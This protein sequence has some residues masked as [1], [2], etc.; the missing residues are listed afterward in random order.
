MCKII[1][2]FSS[3]RNK[4][5]LVSIEDYLR[6]LKIH[7]TKE[8]AMYEAEVLGKLR[9]YVN[10]PKVVQ[11]YSNKLYL[12]YINGK[13]AIEYFLECSINK[14]PSL[15][16]SMISFCKAY[17]DL[18]CDY[19]LSDTN[20][21]N[22]ILV[23]KEDSIDLFGIDFEEKKEGALINS[24]ANLCAFAFLYDVCL[25]KKIG[26][27]NTILEEISHL[28][29]TQN[30]LDEEVLK[31]LHWLINRRKLE[32]KANEVLDGIKQNCSEQGMV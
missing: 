20:F 21:R 22:F 5:F 25:E 2:E 7:N 8:Q 28:G 3:K 6:V 31:S 24:A 10:V 26:F 29:L 19:Y 23:E 32:L 14:V 30:I 17:S 11:V 4:V 13:L 27:Y 9:P 12:E 1:K 18:F 15:A 16:K